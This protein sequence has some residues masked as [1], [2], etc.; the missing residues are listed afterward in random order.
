MMST[1]TIV[2]MLCAFLLSCAAHAEDL[3]VLLLYP[4]D[5]WVG[6]NYDG[7]AIVAQLDGILSAMPGYSG[8]SAAYI[9]NAGIQGSDLVDVWYNPDNTN[10]AIQVLNGD[11]DVIII[12]PKPRYSGDYPEVGFAVVSQMSRH[13]L[14]NGAI[15]LLLM[16]APALADLPKVAANGYRIAN[17][18]GINVMPGGLTAYEAGLL[19]PAAGSDETRQ[20]YAVAATIFSQLT[21]HNAA[22][23]GYVPLYDGSAIDFTN[24]ANTAESVLAANED[25]EHYSE[26]I[27]ESGMVVYRSLDATQ[28]PFNGTVRYAWTGTSTE[29]GINSY[30]PSVISAQSLVAGAYQVGSAQYWGGGQTT[31]AQGNFNSYPD[32]YLFIYTRDLDVTDESICGANQANLLAIELDKHS[33][34]VP[35]GAASTRWLARNTRYKTSQATLTHERLGANAILFHMGLARFYAADPTLVASSDGE[36]ITAP[37]YYMVASMMVSSALG[38][39]LVPPAAVSGNSQYLTGFNIGKAL[40]RELA[41][42]S[43]DGCDIPDTDLQIDAPSLP[44]AYTGLLYQVTLN[45]EGGSAPYT[46]EELSNDGLPT[47]ISFSTNGVLSGTPS[48][49]GTNI[50]VFK[51]TDANNAIRKK[52]LAI[53]VTDPAPINKPII[54]AENISSLTATSAAFNV[55]VVSTGSSPTEVYFYCGAE[56]KGRANAAWQ[57]EMPMGTQ[58]EVVVST[59]LTGLT[60]SAT[61]Y[62]RAFAT[63]SAGGIWSPFSTSFITP[64]DL[65]GQ[66]NSMS[67]TNV[68]YN[69]RET[70]VDF[71]LLLKFSAAISGFSCAGFT[72]SNAYDLRFTD[73]SGQE[74]Y[75]Y[76]I[77]SWDPSGTSCVWVC[78]PAFSS[79]CGLK[80][81]W[82]D[83]VATN[84]RS[85]TTNGS[86][87]KADYQAVY[88]M[89]GTNPVLED[90]SQHADGH[91]ATA[92]GTVT[93]DTASVI[94][95]GVY[96]DGTDGS[97]APSSPDPGH[98]HDA[99]WRRTWSAWVT[100]ENTTNRAVLIEEGG[101][102]YGFGLSY[103]ADADA[104]VLS[105]RSDASE[106][107]TNTAPV[108]SGGAPVHVVGT[109]DAGTLKLYLNGALAASREGEQIMPAHSNDPTIGSQ[110]GS[111]AI[112][113]DHVP[114]H[115]QID[116]V[117][118]ADAVRSADWIWAAYLTVASND[119]AITYT[120]DSP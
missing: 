104:M 43:E 33:S 99:A 5:N 52:A 57:Y 3:D 86:T 17:G 91:D 97:I 116:E 81:L 32:Q 4:A 117:R 83:P 105:Y 114:W 59:N 101:A 41:F 103:D 15:P 66:T 55:T 50:L 36:H 48:T 12:V 73:A 113:G 49:I 78:V 22:D 13:I 120:M 75:D 111:A 80:A 108:G 47:G 53:A 82:G 46:W 39:D 79:D 44:F 95:N 35:A 74:E 89:T 72:S 27:S 21:G 14:N 60:E 40:V 94:G 19:Q 16:D 106:I 38:I 110:N 1:R 30:L 26:S 62:W 92:S 24:L 107:S 28:A 11:Y 42:L 90:A 8:S 70:L 7:A 84:Q 87:W 54:T 112:S 45:A 88:H 29:T 96:F 76:E 58:G 93:R 67:I 10:S 56:D 31:T 71:P 100:L 68:G 65:G 85:C 34:A 118:C 18:C 25:T 6:R 2:T 115:G 109:Y 119:T 98:W 69:G 102:A 20:A 37:L 63:N 51:V 61:Y 23:S 77:E 64:P 9:G